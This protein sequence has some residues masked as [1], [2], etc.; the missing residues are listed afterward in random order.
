M[1]L[2]DLTPVTR[3]ESILDG[4]D[5][6]PV[7]RMEYFLGK[8]ANEVPK[9][10]GVSDAGKVLTV[11]AAGDGFELDTPDSGLPAYTGADLGKVLTVGGT[12][13]NPAAGW[14]VASGGNSGIT[15]LQPITSFTY[16]DED[17]LTEK[18]GTY[19][20]YLQFYFYGMPNEVKG[21]IIPEEQYNLLANGN[22]IPVLTRNVTLLSVL[23]A[24]GYYVPLSELTVSGTNA[25]KNFYCAVSAEAFTFAPSS[26][27]GV[28]TFKNATTIKAVGISLYDSVGNT[29]DVL[30]L[31]D[32][33]EWRKTI[34]GIS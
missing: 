29:F 27:P 15:L 33:V 10:E 26:T 11:N 18:T 6:S 34:R 2:E 13:E 24:I 16:Y 21:I 31:P 23:S 28:Y 5:I 19:V 1:A 8:A 7:T 20:D 17:S 22:A 14:E 4:D 9:P 12:S 25:Q 3:M 32:T 30:V